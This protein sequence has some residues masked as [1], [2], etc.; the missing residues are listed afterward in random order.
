MAHVSPSP[1]LY[2]DVRYGLSVLAPF[3]WLSGGLSDLRHSPGPS[4]FY[5]LGFTVMGWLLMSA[6]RHAIEFATAATT[7]F[8][9]VGPFFA[10]GLYELSRRREK[11]LHC[12]VLETVGIWRSTAGSIGIYSL[13]LILLYLLWA[14]VSVA[15]FTMFYNQGMP[16]ADGFLRQVGSLDNLQFIIAYCAVGGFFASLVF[17]FSVISIPLMLDRN[18]DT[19]AAMTTSFFAVIRNL[20]AML[21]WAAL[22]VALVVVGIGTAYVGMVITMPILGHATWYAYRDLIDSP[23]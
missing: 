8:M 22:I 21:V 10:M 19:V 12:S 5:G 13:I 9:L 1:A 2:P 17:A 15:M 4:M 20:P 7:G 16:T 3:S 23:R 14:G 6:F 18:L 11:K